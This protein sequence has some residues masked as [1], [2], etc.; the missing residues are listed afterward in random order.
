MWQKVP[1]L[2]LCPLNPLESFSIPSAK[3]SH[4]MLVSESSLSAFHRHRRSEAVHGMACSRWPTE[5]RSMYV[6][7]AV[8]AHSELSQ[9]TFSRTSHGQQHSRKINMHDNE[10]R[11]PTTL[12]PGMGVGGGWGG[13][14][15]GGAQAGMG[16]KLL[17]WP[18][19]VQPCP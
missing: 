18:P 12:A 17:R 14:S 6:S 7:P 9:L 5:W 13:W 19:A 1:A 3:I 15:G 2:R 4:F 16:A 10:Q 8:K 11:S